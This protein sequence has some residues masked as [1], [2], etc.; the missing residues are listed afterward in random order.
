MNLFLS[1]ASTG[2]SPALISNFAYCIAG[3]I[4]F[5]TS[6][7]IRSVQPTL[8]LC[9]SYHHRSPAAIII[10]YHLLP[11]PSPTTWCS[12]HYLSSAAATLNNH[13]L[14]LSSPF[15]SCS[16]HHQSRD[17]VTITSH[18]PLPSFTTCYRYDHPPSRALPFIAVHFYLY[19]TWGIPILLAIRVYQILVEMK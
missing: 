12:H 18:L 5:F 6:L 14:Q 8:T 7:L 16:Y 15:T 4:S 11:L 10:T 17:A 19:S 2:A 9:C 1:A 3:Y 13:L